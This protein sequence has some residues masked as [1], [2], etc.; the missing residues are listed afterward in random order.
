MNLSDFLQILGMIGSS[1]LVLVGF[2]K[3]IIN[4]YFKKAN[5]LNIAKA[6]LNQTVLT[7]LK[8]ELSDLKDEVKQ[9]KTKLGIE[10]DKSTASFS[11]LHVKI[12]RFETKLDNQKEM[13]HDLREHSAKIEFQF[14]EFRK[15][16]LSK[17]SFIEKSRIVQIGK[18]TVMIKGGNNG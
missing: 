15:E 1:F 18:D 8:T 9:V 2:A 12:A 5:E 17:I 16:I 4:L 7:S 10:S 3:M 6:K 13:F 14:E 11:E